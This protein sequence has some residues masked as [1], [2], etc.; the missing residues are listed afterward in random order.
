MNNSYNY[1]KRYMNSFIKKNI[2]FNEQYECKDFFLKLSNN[3]NEINY[4]K[5]LNPIRITENNNKV[6]IPFNEQYE[7]KDFK[8]K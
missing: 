1:L 7:C 2:P 6:K 8:L 4:K 5:N 3:S